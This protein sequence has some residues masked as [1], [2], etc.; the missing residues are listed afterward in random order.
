MCLSFSHA[1]KLDRSRCENRAC[2]MRVEFAMK[3]EANQ[4]HPSPNNK[5]CMCIPDARKHGVAVPVTTQ[6]QNASHSLRSRES[7][8]A[9]LQFAH[10]NVKSFQTHQPGHLLSRTRNSNTLETKANG[11]GMVFA[12]PVAGRRITAGRAP[13]TTVFHNKTGRLEAT[14]EI[15]WNSRILDPEGL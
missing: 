4:G 10:M 3:P 11:G 5:D 15:C 2:T 6:Q 13:R 1:D 12:I 8:G 9:C 14:G 7:Q